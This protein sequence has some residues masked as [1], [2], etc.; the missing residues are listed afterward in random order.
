MCLLC[1]VYTSI[2]DFPVGV[3]LEAESDSGLH[4]SAFEDMVI[5]RL[6]GV[7]SRVV[8]LGAGLVGCQKCV[9]PLLKDYL[10][11]KVRGEGEREYVVMLHLC[12]V[13]LWLSASP[14]CTSDQSGP[15]VELSQSA[16]SVMSHL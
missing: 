7:A 9:H 16:T 12:R 1:Y 10:R 14:H 6:M 13:C 4:N 2:I 11:E 3:S 15:S 5:T 8:E